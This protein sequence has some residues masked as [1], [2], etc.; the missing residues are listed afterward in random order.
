TLRDL[1]GIRKTA[2]G[3]PIMVFNT[4]LPFE[5]RR[6]VTGRPIFFPLFG[7]CGGF[8]DLMP[9]FRLTAGRMFRRGLHEL[10]ASNTCVRQFSGFELGAGR[11]VHGVDW[12]AGGLFV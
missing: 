6:R 3:E 1:P 9:E 4:L 7:V 5:G 2:S 11:S 8:C 10:I 12:P